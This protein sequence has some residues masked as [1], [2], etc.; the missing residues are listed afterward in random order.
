M[1]I[2]AV[3][4]DR[5][6]WGETAAV[7]YLEPAVLHGNPRLCCVFTSRHAGRSGRTLNLGVDQGD[8]STVLANRQRVLR[9]L[10]LGQRSLYTVHQVHGNQVC[11][12]DAP[13]VHRGLAGVRADALVTTLPEVPLGVVVADCLPIVLYSLQ[14]RLLALVHGGRMGTYHRIVPTVLAVLRR[15]FRVLPE[16]VYAVIG[17]GIGACCYRLDARAIRPFQERFSDWE[18]FCMPQGKGFWSMSLTRATHAQ[19]DAA[20]V[21]VAHR[22]TADICT[23]CHN[24][25]FYS[26]RAEGQKAGR[27]MG[28]AVLRS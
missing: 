24:E 9:A 21:P 10:G 22:Q 12:V 19:L 17:P 25:H 14:P 18:R 4:E 7:T 3:R 15:R 2:Q 5:W 26:H 6:R 23:V 20:G 27:G 28:I 1:L 8:R 16:Q 11:I 13:A